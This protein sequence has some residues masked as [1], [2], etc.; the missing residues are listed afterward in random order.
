MLVNLDGGAS[1]SECNRPEYDVPSAATHST[2]MSKRSSSLRHKTHGTLHAGVPS[3]TDRSIRIHPLVFRRTQ[4][5]I[6]CGGTPF[7]EAADIQA[8]SN[9]RSAQ[10]R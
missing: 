4:C 7:L 2:A 3:R 10:Q 5:T 1:G 9:V 8:S 6:E